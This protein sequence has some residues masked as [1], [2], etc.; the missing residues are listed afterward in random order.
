VFYQSRQ[1]SSFQKFS[2]YIW[3]PPHTSETWGRVSLPYSKVEQVLKN[4][5]R[6]GSPTTITAVVATLF[7]RV[8]NK[9][10]QL[11][12]FIKGKKIV[13]HNKKRVFITTHFKSKTKQWDLSGISLDD[14]HQKSLQAVT[15]EIRQK[16]RQIKQGRDNEINRFSKCITHSPH[17]LLSFIIPVIRY[18][19]FTIGFTIEKVGFPGDRFGAIMITPL[20]EFGIETAKVPLHHFSN[21]SILVAICKPCWILTESGKEK[22]LPLDITIDHRVLDGKASAMAIQTLHDELEK[23]L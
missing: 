18:L 4:K 21:A 16:S 15:S 23:L 3:D 7:G 17:W 9:H 5:K 14:S 10:P 6:E 1:P 20:H 2:A 8:L 11:N 22:R 13:N 12:T 19:V